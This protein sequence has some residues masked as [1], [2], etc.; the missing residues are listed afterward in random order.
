M[1][2]MISINVKIVKKVET[3]I[4]N[5]VRMTAGIDE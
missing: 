2:V 3:R 1:D 5:A 4:E